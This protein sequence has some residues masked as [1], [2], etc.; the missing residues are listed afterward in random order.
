MPNFIPPVTGR[1]SPVANEVAAVALVVAV[2]AVGAAVVLANPDNE[3]NTGTAEV[4]FGVAKPRESP[5]PAELAGAG[6][7]PNLIPTA[8][9]V[10]PPEDVVVG[11]APS[12]SPVLLPPRLNPVEADVAAV[13]PP[14]NVNAGVEATEVGAVVLL[15]PRVKPCDGAYPNIK[16]PACVFGVPIVELKSP[17]G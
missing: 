15:P 6:A 2:L 8:P 17:V 3:P 9:R 1:E 11:V 4:L 13:G 7:P 12:V 14:P 10:N 5:G 16:P